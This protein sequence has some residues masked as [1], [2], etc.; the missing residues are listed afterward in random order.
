MC[1]PHR[2]AR[3]ARGRPPVRATP[4]PRSVGTSKAGGQAGAV[5]NR[6]LPPAGGIGKPRRKPRA[7]TSTRCTIPALH[8]WGCPHSVAHTALHGGGAQGPRPRSSAMSPIRDGSRRL[9]PDR[10][11]R[12]LTSPALSPA[13]SPLGGIPPGTS[14]MPVRR[15][16]GVRPCH[17]PA[18]PRD[19]TRGA[20]T[21]TADRQVGETTPSAA[22]INRLRQQT[23]CSV[24]GSPITS[25]VTSSVTGGRRGRAGQ[26]VSGRSSFRSRTATSAGLVQI[27][28]SGKC[29]RILSCDP[30][31]V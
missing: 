12:R 5:R 24:T 17:G 20:R 15:R 28:A 29:E 19:V 6:H 25:P 27:G 31:P 14:R 1:R 23:G 9:P 21:S 7:P 26:T 18:F 8:A 30:R 22:G 4:Q 11:P 10:A 2:A 13:L 16:A 3:G